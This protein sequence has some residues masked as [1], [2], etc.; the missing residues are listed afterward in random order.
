M[1]RRAVAS[2]IGNLA[3]V[4]TKDIVVNEL[5][6]IFKQLSSDEQVRFPGLAVVASYF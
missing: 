4:V 1:V 6:P 5:I 2:R 3:T